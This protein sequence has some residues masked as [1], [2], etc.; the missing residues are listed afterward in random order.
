MEQQNES[1][2]VNPPVDGTCQV[3]REQPSKYTCPRC[4]MR[5]C[6]V[7]C[8]K[9][10][11]Q[12]NDCSGERSKTHF[13]SRDQ[14][15]YSNMMSDYVYLEDVSRKSD[16]LSR[17]RL[18]ADR[19]DPWPVEQRNRA[20]VKQVRAM[21]VNYS[22]LPSGMSRHKMNKTNYSSN[23]HQVFWSIECCF[24]QKGQVQR[25]VEHSF[26]SAKPLRG[27]FDNLLFTETPQGKGAYSVI[28][29]QAKDFVNAGIER[30]IVALKK[31]E[32]PKDTF[33]DL[34]PHLDR[35]WKDLLRGERI[36]EF[37]TLYIWLQ[38]DMDNDIKLEEKVFVEGPLPHQQSKSKGPRR[39]KNDNNN[40]HDSTSDQMVPSITT[41]IEE[42]KIPEQAKQDL[43]TKESVAAVEHVN[44]ENELAQP[45]DT[46]SSST[47]PTIEDNKQ[48]QQQHE[49]EQGGNQNI[50]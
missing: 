36:I 16:T 42:P 22:M 43:D 5:T 9:Q 20:L 18:R 23:F 49:Y 37:P 1:T 11:K 38:G 24:C 39:Q 2:A 41:G 26:P 3:C 10:H 27:F 46:P 29:Y 7:G 48:Q 45:L 28:R 19:R 47:E 30:F 8:V 21:G 12:D 15:N 32:G 14:Y 34:T 6:S 35:T 4:N 17:E 31:P 44:Q 33:I 50:Q 13:V 40:N 25:I